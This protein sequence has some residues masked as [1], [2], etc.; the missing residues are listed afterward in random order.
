V[1]RDSVA[2]CVLFCMV[3][4]SLANLWENLT[5][6]CLH[7]VHA[8]PI[9]LRYVIATA[10]YRYMYDVDF[11][12]WLLMYKPKLLAKNRISCTLVVS[13]RH[14]KKYTI[15]ACQAKVKFNAQKG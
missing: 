3:W 1:H 5:C 12:R 4:T 7:L 14:S 11:F 6:C 13:V 15:T 2:S 8:L 9:A 10:K